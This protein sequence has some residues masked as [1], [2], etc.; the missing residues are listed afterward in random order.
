MSMY[1]PVPVN[2]FCTTTSWSYCRIYDSFINR[3]YFFVAKSTSSSISSF[4]ISGTSSYP[5]AI[6]VATSFYNTLL[7]VTQPGNSRYL[8]S[9]SNARTSS[10]NFASAIYPQT[11]SKAIQPSMF[12][13]FLETY[14]T[15]MIVSVYLPGRKI[16]S[17]SRD[18]G[19]YRGSFIKVSFSGLTNLKGCSATL[20]ARPINMDA[21]FY[22]E[23]ISNS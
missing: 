21:P 12:G 3:K 18:Y 1:A 7:Y 16:Y 4:R 19:Q 10:P 23:V 5:P 6:D 11:N 13:S 2:E 17:V 14:N 9:Y 8:Y 20:K 22:C 15:S